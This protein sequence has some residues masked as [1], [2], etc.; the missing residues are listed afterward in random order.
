MAR[1]VV[2]HVFAAFALMGLPALAS[3]GRFIYR[4][5][6]ER[7][8]KERTK[9]AAAIFLM[10]FGSVVIMAAAVNHDSMPRPLRRKYLDAYYSITAC[11]T[12]ISAV[13]LVWLTHFASGA[14]NVAWLRRWAWLITA[15]A[16]TAGALLRWG[17]R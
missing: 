12:L 8:L 14:W 5:A 11:G 9:L 10:M 16:G 6:G 17:F 7:P 13:G 15:A 1:D 4:E 3:L 2:F